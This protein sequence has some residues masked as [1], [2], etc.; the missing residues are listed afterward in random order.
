MSAPSNL[1]FLFLHILSF[2]ECDS[3]HECNLLD[4]FGASNT[5]DDIRMLSHQP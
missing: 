1:L 4:S 5:S 3:L 2:Q